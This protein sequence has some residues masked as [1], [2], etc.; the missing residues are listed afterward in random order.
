MEDL[1]HKI[2][3]Y[4]DELFDDLGPTELPEDKKADIFAR[5]EERL[6]KLI[7]NRAGPGLPRDK[8]GALASALQQQDYAAAD[9]LLKL[10]S[11]D[12]NSLNRAIDQEM[13]EFKQIIEKEQKYERHDQEK[14]RALRSG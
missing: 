3:E 6:H 1:G 12:T 8:A 5:V 9:K 7:L 2:E 10:A 11:N 4:V 13:K 14:G